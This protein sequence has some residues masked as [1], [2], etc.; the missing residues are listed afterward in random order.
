MSAVLTLRPPVEEVRAASTARRA[1]GDRIYVLHDV[2]GL[3]GGG[4]LAFGLIV[5]WGNAGGATR[6]RTEFFASEDARSAR[7]RALLGR[8]RRS[9]YLTVY[10]VPPPGGRSA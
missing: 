10:G 6:Q 7:R 8:R 5:T 1:R 9:G 4:A 3:F 2:R